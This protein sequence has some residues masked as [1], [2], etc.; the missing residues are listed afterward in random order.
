MNELITSLAYRSFG[1]GIPVVLIH[2]FCEDSTMWDDVIKQ[3][4][5]GLRI[6]LV[7]MPGFGKTPISKAISIE[8][9]AEAVHALV[10]SL[11]IKKYFLFGHSM[12]GYV[13]LSILKKHEGNLLGFGLIHSHPFADSEDQVSNRNKAIDF[14]N[15]FGASLYIKQIIPSL[16]PK[17]FVTS[18]RFLLER[19]V[20]NAN[21][22][23]A[24]GITNAL[25]AMRDRKDHSDILKNMSIP[26][27]SIIGEND[28]LIPTERFLKQASMAKVTKLEFLTKIGHMGPFENPKLINR[29]IQN[30]VAEFHTAS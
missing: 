5:D 20:F 1:S 14:I 24:L 8:E 19:L 26:F 29:A 3:G 17:S 15:K 23:P 9:I 22:Y 7:D 16:F 12:G 4:H 10:I 27:L 28:H 6:I 13:G 30:F 21:K 25:S 2:G 18:N 11:G